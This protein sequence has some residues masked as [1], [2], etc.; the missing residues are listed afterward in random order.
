MTPLRRRFVE[1]LTLRNYSPRTIECYVALV[2]RFAAHFGRSPEELGVEVHAVE[3]VPVTAAIRFGQI[4][5]RVVE[6][7]LAALYE[8][9]DFRA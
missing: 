4:A 5:I 1:D 3:R 7:P 2:A 9:M 8:E 6:L